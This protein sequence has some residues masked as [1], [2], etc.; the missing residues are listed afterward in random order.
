VPTLAGCILLAVIVGAGAAA[1]ALC[2]SGPLTRVA[3]A[4]Q[5]PSLAWLAGT[6]D[7]GR[8]VACL[9]F[10]GL[11]TSLVIGVATGLV[12]LSLGTLVGVLAGLAV[13]WTDLLLMRLAELAQTMPRLFLAILAVALFE[14]HTISLILVLGLTSWGR[15]ARFVRAEAMTLSARQFV[16]AARALG[17]ATPRL[18]LRHV[19]PN[20][21]HPLLATAGPTVASAILAE[22][23]LSYVGLGDLDNISLGRSIAAAYPFMERAWWMSAAPAAALFLVTVAFM[24]LVETADEY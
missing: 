20:L 17:V 13:G 5:P 18:M 10:Y 6:D 15:L 19:V 23:A 9:T 21:R 2:P 3:P 24:L 1:P 4:L 8:S 11:R 14:V 7:I 16:L 12:V 22:A